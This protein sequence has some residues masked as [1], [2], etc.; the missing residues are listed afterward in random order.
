MDK[1]NQ[2]KEKM[3][4]YLKEID[5]V[6]AKGPYKDDSWETMLGHKVPDWYRNA[7]FGIFIHWGAYAV[8]AYQTEWYTCHM[9]NEEGKLDGKASGGAE[10][11]K[12]IYQHHLETYGHVKDFNY[13]H[14]IPMFTA[15]QFDAKAWV[16]LF[17]EA[18]ARFVMPVA[19]HCDGFPMYDCSLTDWCASKKGPQKDTLGLLKY[20]IEKR[21]MMLAT[22]SHRMEHYWFMGGI[23]ELAPDLE[24]PY[25]DLYWPSYKKEFQLDD[26]TVTN[27]QDVTNLTYLDPLFMEDWLVRCCE[28]VDKYRP[29]IM[30]F[31]WWIQVNPMKPYLRKF[32]AYYYNR[33]LEWGQEVTINYKNDAF[34]HTVGVKD[35]ER[36][37]LTDVS[38]FYWQ[39][40]TAIARNSW[41]YTENNDY[42]SV[43]EV[44][45]TLVDVVSKNGSL[46]LNVGPKAD[47]TISE[48]DT[49]VLKGVGAWL[50]VNGEAIYESIPWRKHGEGPTVTQEGHFSDQNFLGYTPDDYRFT[51]N[52]GCLYVFAMNYPEDGVMRIKT[53]G[54][55]PRKNQ[56]NGH[57]KEVSILGQ[58]ECEFYLSTENL[59]V[60]GEKG[61]RE[62]PVCIK[63]KFE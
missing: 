54:R 13:K 58:K 6:I 17:E 49:K 10:G 11:K 30:Y 46:C 44:L 21:G 53:L 48:E 38:P 43:Y 47:G 32:A 35:I 14:F 31:D 12:S 62:T 52:K 5:E 42:K 4:A 9:H 34:A 27:H 57:I 3:K 18:G 56:F 50:K 29:K 28:I 60:Y 40:D 39:N 1:A 59:T 26:G 25:G 23:R 20:E 36:G 63:I 7:K 22:S 37:Q 45:C 51:F 8:P 16:D 19:E 61:K 33:A 41:C 2:F 24:I 55:H 15:Q